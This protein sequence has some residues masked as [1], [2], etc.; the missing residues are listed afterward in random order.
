MSTPAP[1]TGQPQFIIIQSDGGGK[2]N[3]LEKIQLFGVV[4][5]LGVGG[6]LI[7]EVFISKDGACEGSILGKNGLIGQLLP[8]NPFCEGQAIISFFSGFKP[9]GDAGTPIGLE[10]C[11]AGYNDIGM[12]CSRPMS[13]ASGLDFFSKGCSGGETVGKL[14]HGGSCPADRDHIDA[15]CYKKCPTGYTHVEL[16]PYMCRPTAGGNFIDAFTKGFQIPSWL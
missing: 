15:L 8:Y 3:A 9:T 10:G 5:G 14:D 1:A 4:L 16:M 12:L 2:M 7:Y 13:C 6:Y 11:P